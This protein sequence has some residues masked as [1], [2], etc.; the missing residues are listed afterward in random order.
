MRSFFAPINISKRS[1][2]APSAWA[3][4]GQCC[5]S[6]RRTSYYGR[7]G[8]HHA[9]D[10]LLDE[11]AVER[12]L[13]PMSIKVR[14]TLVRAAMHARLGITPS[15][16][17]PREIRPR[18]RVH[19]PALQDTPDLLHRPRGSTMKQDLYGRGRARS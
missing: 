11:A 6:H 9:F 15:K 14:A 7:T 3:A 4:S 10:E 2:L 18:Y 19:L 1:A 16:S 13:P 5:E 17:S 12:L 8:R